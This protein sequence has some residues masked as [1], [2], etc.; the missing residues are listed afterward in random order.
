MLNFYRE[1]MGGE[2]G[3]SKVLKVAMEHDCRN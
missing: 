3:Q 1:F 2:N